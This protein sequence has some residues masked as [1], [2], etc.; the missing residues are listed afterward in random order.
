MTAVLNET[1]PDAGVPWHYGDPLGEQRTLERGAASVDLRH[2]PVFTVSGP[3]RLTWLDAVSSQRFTGL[4]PG[5]STAALLLD[6]QGR[7]EHA[8]GGV[9]D[10]ETFWGHTEPGRLEALLA[11]LNSLRF[12]AK[13]E[14]ADRT[15]ERAVIADR[16][17]VRIVDRARVEA[18]LGDR[19]AGTWASEALRIAAG[20]PRFFLDHDDRAIPN[21]LFA[22]SGEALGPAVH[23]AKG[24]YRGQETVGRTYTLGRPPRRLVLL[25]LDGSVNELPEVGAPLLAGGEEVGRV[26][27][28][29]VHHELGPIALGLVRRTLPV[30]AT[31]AVAGIAA[32]QEVVVDPEVGLH[33]RRPEGLLAQIPGRPLR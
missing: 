27:T 24:C 2:R 6:G 25:H 10:G 13:V 26:G 5:A 33:V 31:L 22:P 14:V 9:D 23:L 11:Q 20:R 15:G 12:A 28:S 29:A 4:A 32:A 7:I 30:T 3:D 18:E 1:G 21:E 19:R 17:G 16:A 8:F